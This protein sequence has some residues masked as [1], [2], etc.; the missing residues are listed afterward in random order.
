VHM[1]GSTVGKPKALAFWRKSRALPVAP[2]LR[3]AGAEMSRTRPGAGTDRHS[4]QCAF[5]SW[6]ADALSH[7]G[8]IRSLWEVAVECSVVIS[9]PQLVHDAQGFGAWEFGLNYTI[10]DPH[11]PTCW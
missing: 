9:V 6:L 2:L 7:E 10:E 8:V 4:I 5:R 1:L 11:L 3:R